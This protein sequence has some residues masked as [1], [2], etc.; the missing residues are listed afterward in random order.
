METYK[1]RN[2]KAQELREIIQIKKE[3]KLSFSEYNN[4]VEALSPG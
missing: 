2:K 3:F 4:T 1:Q